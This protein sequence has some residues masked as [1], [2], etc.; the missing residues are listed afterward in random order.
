MKCYAATSRDT[1]VELWQFLPCCLSHLL[2]VWHVVG[3]EEERWA[4]RVVS[5][6]QGGR[7]GRTRLHQL[8]AEDVGAAAAPGLEGV[9]EAVH[10][11]GE[12]AELSLHAVHPNDL[13]VVA[14]VELGRRA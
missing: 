14:A 13:G 12:P 8:A 6:V 3:A 2:C 5:E 11:A 4:R 1:C 9:A 7:D 10:V